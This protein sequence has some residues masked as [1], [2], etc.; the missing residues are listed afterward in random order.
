MCERHFDQTT[1]FCSEC[2]T[3]MSGGPE[4]QEEPPADTDTD[5]HIHRF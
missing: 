1:G 5:T 2:T 4:P 3:E